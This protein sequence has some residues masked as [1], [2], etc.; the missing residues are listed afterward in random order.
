[1]DALV[2]E[3]GPVQIHT[4]PDQGFSMPMFHPLPVAGHRVETTEAVESQ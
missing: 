4:L 2:R 3:P 1:M